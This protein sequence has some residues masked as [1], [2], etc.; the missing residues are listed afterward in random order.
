MNVKLFTYSYV[1]NYSEDAKNF[2]VKYREYFDSEPHTLTN[3][4]YDLGLY[5]IPLAPVSESVSR[6]LFIRRIRKVFFRFSGLKKCVPTADG[7]IK[8]Y[9]LSIMDLII[10]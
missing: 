1:D 5:F 3:K 4:A 2:A 9:T 8:D 7:K 6:K 10:R